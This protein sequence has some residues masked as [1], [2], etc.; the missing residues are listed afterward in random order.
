[1]VGVSKPMMIDG[2]SLPGRYN[3]SAGPCN[4][5]GVGQSVMVMP[6]WADSMKVPQIRAG[7]VPP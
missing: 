4:G 7:K 6:E 3:R 2:H 5:G 1:M